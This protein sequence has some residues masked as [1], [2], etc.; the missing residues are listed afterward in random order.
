MRFYFAILQF[1]FHSTIDT[2]IVTYSLYILAYYKVEYLDHL[3]SEY[4]QK[5]DSVDTVMNFT[6]YIETVVIIICKL[7]NGPK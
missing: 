5:V 6:V 2:P 3:S 1:C 4:I 7:A